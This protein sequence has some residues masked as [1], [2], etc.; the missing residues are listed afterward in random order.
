[1]FGLFDRELQENMNTM[2][3]MVGLKKQTH[4]TMNRLKD[5]IGSMMQKPGHSKAK[6][7]D[8]KDGDNMRK[9]SQL[10]TAKKNV[11]KIRAHTSKNLMAEQ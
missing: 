9:F 8:S 6:R 1:M 7:M 5:N 2:K 11:T 10:V 4:N 3:K